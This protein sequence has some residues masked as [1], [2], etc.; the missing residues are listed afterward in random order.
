MDGWMELTEERKDIMQYTLCAAA[1]QK[2]NYFIS[3]SSHE[4]RPEKY[5]LW[6]MC[7]SYNNDL[8]MQEMW[9]AYRPS[10]DL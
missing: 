9:H 5:M 1:F 10:I 3:E 6:N 7:A 8:N 4:K 2:L